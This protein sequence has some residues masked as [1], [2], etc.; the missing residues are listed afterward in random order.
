MLSKKNSRVR[1]SDYFR[2]LNDNFSSLQ[3]S[4][5]LT[6]SDR[7]CNLESHGDSYESKFAGL[8]PLVNLTVNLVKDERFNIV[9][10]VLQ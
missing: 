6:A 7:Y 4:S 1:D 5:S 9:L 2:E 8:S 3:E 10:F